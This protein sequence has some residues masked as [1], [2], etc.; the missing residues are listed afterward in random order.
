LTLD[1]IQLIIVRE[2]INVCQ[3]EDSAQGAK[4][5]ITTARVILFVSFFMLFALPASGA[6]EVQV[7]GI[8]S[9]NGLGNYLQ[10]PDGTWQTTATLQGATGAQ[11]PQGPTGPQGVTGTTGPQGPTGAQGPQGIQGPAGP[12]AAGVKSA[13][14]DNDIDITSATAASIGSITVSVPASGKVIVFASG[15]VG[16]KTHPVSTQVQLLM[17]LSDASADLT[18]GAGYGKF[19]LPNTFPAFLLGQSFW[20]PFNIVRVFSVS[21]AGSH[22]YFFNAALS[23]SGATGSFAALTL[24]A[25]Y[26]PNGL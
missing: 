16:F 6:D 17:K 26:V 20:T 18:A 12:G 24:T 23:V 14:D 2:I 3:A 11:G 21:A 4:M 10:F 1:F 15:S 22:T 13:T 7:D 5:A 19:V 25:L 9:I 8:L